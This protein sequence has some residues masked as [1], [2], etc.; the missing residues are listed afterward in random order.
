MTEQTI[1]ESE[2]LSVSMNDEEVT[3]SPTSIGTTDLCGGRSDTF[4]GY[5]VDQAIEKLGFGPFQLVTFLICSL[6]WFATVAEKMILTVLSPA[7]KCQ[8]LL[9]SN[10]EAII[11]AITF[12]GCSLGSIFWGIMADKFGRK[13]LF[14]EQFWSP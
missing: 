13:K 3:N 12:V 2:M 9:S 6:T 11:T 7:V 1:R 14:L 4:S 8:W 5:T 10:E